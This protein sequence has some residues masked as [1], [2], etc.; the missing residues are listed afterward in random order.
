MIMHEKSILAL[1][2]F[3]TLVPCNMPQFNDQKNHTDLVFKVGIPSSIDILSYSLSDVL[4][5]G[6]SAGV[7]EASSDWRRG[8]RQGRSTAGHTTASGPQSRDNCSRRWPVASPGYLMILSAGWKEKEKES[9]NVTHGSCN[10]ST[11]KSWWKNKNMCCC[12]EAEKEV[13]VNRNLFLNSSLSSVISISSWI[14]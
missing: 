14:T 6:G 5:C 3:A 12:K 1:N 2:P 13:K 7:A 8:G 9:V 10:Q 11:L 4:K